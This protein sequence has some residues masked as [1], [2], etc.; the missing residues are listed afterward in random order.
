MKI[1]HMADAHLD[2][3]MESKLDKSKAA[4]RRDELLDTFC[5]ITEYAEKEAVSAVIIAGDL[6]D[7]K[8]ARVTAVSRVKAA[9]ADHKNI[10]FYYLRG[11]HDEAG[12][13]EGED[14]PANLVV[15][16]K[17]GITSE[18]LNTSSGN[19]IVITAINPGQGGFDRSYSQLNLE[20]EAMN[21]VVMHGAA[22]KY[23]GGNKAESIDL[24]RLKNRNIDYL[25][26]GHYHSYVEGDLPSRGFYCYSGCIEGRGFDECGEK[27]FV[28]LDIDDDH[29]TY[30]SKFVPYSKRKIYEVEADISKCMTVPE[31]DKCVD[32]ALRASG[33]IEDDIVRVV[34]TGETDVNAEKDLLHVKRRIEDG[35]FYG[36]VKDKS[37]IAIDYD[38]YM[39]EASLKGELVRLLK[40]DESLTEEERGRIVKCAVQALK[41]EEISL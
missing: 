26:L 6:F 36:E 23:R 28:L 2:S 3:R 35:F 9:I 38:E 12:Y 16:G 24:S 17:E 25:A 15:F 20:Y 22:D 31:I 27:G 29:L 33:A 5:A 11:N 1:I 30:E 41:G 40:D 32:D 10:K 34:L 18:T 13:F 8:N 14:I 4:L 21:I 19:H 7:T 39:H 37:S